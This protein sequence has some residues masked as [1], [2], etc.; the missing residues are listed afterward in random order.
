MIGSDRRALL[1]AT[2]IGSAPDA[3][4]HPGRSELGAAACGG[5]PRRGGSIQSG[6]VAR[7]ASTHSVV[8]VE[9]PSGLESAYPPRDVGHWVDSSIRV[10]S[11]RLAG[12]RA[13]GEWRMADG[14]GREM[15]GRP[16]RWGDA[17]CARVG[18]RAQHP[19][20]R[21]PPT[22]PFPQALFRG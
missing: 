22:A 21:E 20:P 18:N 5:C 9:V 14:A 12:R 17:T 1:T 19:P 4:T 16:R 8:A 10:L 11:T 13:D 15:R 6:R 7:G 3:A 2:P